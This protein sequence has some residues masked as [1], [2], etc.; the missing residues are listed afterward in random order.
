MRRVA[1]ALTLLLAACDDPDPGAAGATGDEMAES[2][3]GSSESSGESEGS[4]SSTGEEEWNGPLVTVRFIEGEE[5]RSCNDLCGAS[6]C[7]LSERLNDSA[8]CDQQNPDRCG[9]ADDPEVE[10]WAEPTHA[11]S[12]CIDLTGLPRPFDSCATYCDEHGLGACAWVQSSGDSCPNAVL[13]VP[14]VRSWPHHDV[15]VELGG[16]R[17]RFA[18]E[19]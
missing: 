17:G 6:E 5:S 16:S 3:T 1:L 8:D 18:C 2:S 4:G 9:C 13:G 19:L 14:A 15:F 7:I 10:E 11:L 12:E